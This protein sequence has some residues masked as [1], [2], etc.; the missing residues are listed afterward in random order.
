MENITTVSTKEEDLRA[1][2]TKNVNIDAVVDSEMDDMP[3]KIQSPSCCPK[4]KVSYKDIVAASEVLDISPDEMVQA[5]I[6]DLFHD[7]DNSN[8]EDPNLEDFNPN[9]E[10]Q[11]TYEEYKDRCKPWRNTLIAKLLGRKISLRFLSSRLQSLWAVQ[12]QVKVIDLDDEFF[13]GHPISYPSVPTHPL[14]PDIINESSLPQVDAL[15][16]LDNQMEEDSSKEMEED[17][18]MVNSEKH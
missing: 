15:H 14:A 18:S 6:E 16:N 11:V 12:G 8:D 13:M 9:P 10:V 2:S 1:R 5:V 3:E 7:L 17:P 4:N